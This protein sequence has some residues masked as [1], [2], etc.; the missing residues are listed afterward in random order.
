MNSIRIIFSALILFNCSTIQGKAEEVRK[1]DKF[2]HAPVSK[3]PIM[4]PILIP[5][6]GPYNEHDQNGLL[7]GIT[8]SVS[9]EGCD[10]MALKFV[11]RINRIAFIRECWASHHRVLTFLPP[12]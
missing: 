12:K 7:R 4:K 8:A 10:R 6:K 11:A 3:I 1:T 5:R 2:T 9:Q